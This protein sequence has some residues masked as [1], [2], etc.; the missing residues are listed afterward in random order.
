MEC[1]CILCSEQRN[2]ILRGPKLEFV[3]G[4]AVRVSLPLP[5][6]EQWKHALRRQ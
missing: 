5:G 1:A 4:E 3:R 6:E 2:Q